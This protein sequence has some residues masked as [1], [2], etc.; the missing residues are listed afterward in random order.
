MSTRVSP[1]VC[2]LLVFCRHVS[3]L[4]LE[5][6]LPRS[7]LSCFLRCHMAQLWLPSPGCK[8]RRRSCGKQAMPRPPDLA[9]AARQAR[10]T[11]AAA[12]HAAAEAARAAAAAEEV[13][14]RNRQLLARTRCCYCYC[15]NHSLLRI[16]FLLLVL[17]RLTISCCLASYPLSPTLCLLL[18]AS[19]TFTFS[20]LLQNDY[21]HC[22]YFCYYPYHCH[23]CIC[24]CDVALLLPNLDFCQ[25]RNV[26]VL[27]I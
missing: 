4:F 27:N 17:Y 3:S 15:Q 26:Q 6:C 20:F 5:A 12:A 1:S 8:D 25:N 23:P 18:F 2:P 16:D 24:C 19:Q 22:Y 11:A 21:Y 10:A 7:R 13:A 9:E 14:A